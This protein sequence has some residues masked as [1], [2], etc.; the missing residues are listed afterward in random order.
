MS[1][2]R[3]E[4]REPGMEIAPRVHAIGPS[5]N[6]LSQGGYSRAYLFEGEDGRLTLV[7]TLWDEDAHLI[8]K[9]LWKIGRTPKDI[10]HI[11]MTHAHRS[12]LGGLAT[13]K[14]LSGAPVHSHAAEAPI[15]Q[16][17]KQ[18]AKIPLWPLKPP[19]LIGFRV[20][21][22]FGWY[23][24]AR[25]KVDD[26]SLTDGSRVGPLDVLYMPGHTEGNLAFAFG[27][28][29]LAVADTIMTWPSFS[30]GWPGFNQDDEEFERSLRKVIDLK[31]EVVLTGHGDPLTGEDAR[32][33]STLVD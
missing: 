28:R 10:A 24:H 2:G 5:S 1:A 21:S 15:I 6:G 7:D 29:I 26:P 4:Y 20:A 25:C 3:L 31:P 12:H 16:G 23:P 8:L 17:E 27:E 9:Y 33:I 22:Q 19:Q 11:A 30:A 32:R 13:L 14:A 18:A